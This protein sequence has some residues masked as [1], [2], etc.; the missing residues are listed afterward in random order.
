MSKFRPTVSISVCSWRLFCTGR[1]HLGA[2][3]LSIVRSFEVVCIS[4]VKNVLVLWSSCSG[5]RG[6]S[7]VWRLSVSWRVRYGRFHCIMAMARSVDKVYISIFIPAPNPTIALETSIIQ[8]A[9]PD[10]NAPQ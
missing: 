2:G 6:L 9:N 3:F 5:A 8:L 1:C 10:L 7:V 4:E